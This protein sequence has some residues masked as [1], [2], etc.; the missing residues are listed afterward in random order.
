MTA[1]AAIRAVSGWSAATAAMGSPW[2]RTTSEANTGRSA[3]PRPYSGLP[4]TS[5]WVTTARTPGI[6]RACVVSMEVILARAAGRAA[7]PPRAGPRPTGRPRTGRCPRSSRA[8]RRRAGRSRGRAGSAPGR[9]GPAAPAAVAVVAV[10]ASL[11]TPGLRPVPVRV[12]VRVRFRIRRG[13]VRRRVVRRVLRLVRLLPRLE[14]RRVDAT[15]ARAR[16]VRDAGLVAAGFGRVA[17]GV[18]VALG[19]DLLDGVDHGPVAGAAA[20]V[21]AQRLPGLQ[22][23]RRRV[24]LQQV[25]H[26]H[27]H[28]GHAEPALHRSAPGQRPLHV[29]GLS[30]G[31]QAL[32]GAHLAAGRGHG[33]YQAGGHEPPFDLHVARPA[34][35]LRAAV[36]GA[37]E[38][39]PFAQHV[40]QRLADPRVGDGPV[41]AVDAQH[42]GGEGVLVRAVGRGGPRRARRG[43]VP[44]PGPAPRRR[45]RRTARCPRRARSPDAPRPPVPARPPGTPRRHPQPGSRRP[46][47]PPRRP[48]SP[49]CPQTPRGTRKRP[50]ERHR[51]PRRPPRCTCPARASTPGARVPGARVPG[52]RVP[53]AR[54]RGARNR[55][56]RN[57]R[58]PARRK[59]ARRRAARAAA[60]RAGPARCAVPSPPGPTSAPRPP[61]PRARGRRR[62]G[63]RAGCRPTARPG[64]TW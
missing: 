30:V 31:G 33:G 45:T 9:A 15:G 11:L 56:A 8:R 24:A 26:R 36:L 64:R 16:L 53:D 42:V 34:L 58:R 43:P 6:A 14:R 7:R 55:G 5:S 52:A 54:N 29:R 57:R 41:A 32:D 40:Q 46:W 13:V 28:A 3:L 1:A 51:R 17:R 38:A 61:S 63:S 60:A 18:R 47:R 59:A 37:R 22:L 23:G 62:A 12:R 21:A 2:W 50:P 48:G 25:V 19:D 49:R 39:E 4:G 44:R 27:R 20:Q 35:A 10:A